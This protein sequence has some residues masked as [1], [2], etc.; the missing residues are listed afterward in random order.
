M[1][2]HG[3]CQPVDHP[4]LGREREFL[5]PRVARLGVVVLAVQVRVGAGEVVAVEAR[6]FAPGRDRLQVEAGRLPVDNGGGAAAVTLVDGIFARPDVAQVATVLEDRRSAVEL[7]ERERE[8]RA[9]EPVEGVV[10]V[11]LVEVVRDDVDQDGIARLDTQARAKRIG[12]PVVDRIAGIEVRSVA[13]VLFP[14]A[15]DAHRYSIAERAADRALDDFR[16]VVAV[17]QVG[18]ALKLVRGLLGDKVDDAGRRAAAIG[19]AL[20]A[21]QHFDPR[22]V[23]EIEQ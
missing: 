7:G 6:E 10:V 14:L 20:R 4:R 1:E 22:N 18:I 15:G 19:G 21:T 12:V 8:D 23:A 5:A 16:G 11:V 17:G 3:A 2:V 9:A 13:V